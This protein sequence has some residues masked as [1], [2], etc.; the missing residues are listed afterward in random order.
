[1]QQQQAKNYGWTNTDSNKSSFATTQ[2]VFISPS[3]QLLQEFKQKREIV[4]NKSVL[5]KSCQIRLPQ[6]GQNFSK[7]KK[8]SDKE[9][10]KVPGKGLREVNTLK[11]CKEI[12]LDFSKYDL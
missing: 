12:R 6:T 4:S 7:I 1:M 10:S 11:P 9:P 5:A 8:V 2:S 3:S